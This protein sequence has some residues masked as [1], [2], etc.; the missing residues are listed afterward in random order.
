MTYEERIAK[1]VDEI[2]KRLNAAL[3][4]AWD[5]GLRCEVEVIWNSS[6]SAPADRP[7]V[8]VQL[9]RPVN[10]QAKGQ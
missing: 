1:E 2:R 10:M 4:E 5:H 9:L 6:I 8:S 7:M 3:A